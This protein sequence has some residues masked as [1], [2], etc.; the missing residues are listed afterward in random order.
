MVCLP[1]L[2]EYLLYLSIPL[3]LNMAKNH[4][5]LLLFFEREYTRAVGACHWLITLKF[6]KLVC[7]LIYDERMP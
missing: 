5:L 4:I 7:P 1:N 3:S 6:S 2:F